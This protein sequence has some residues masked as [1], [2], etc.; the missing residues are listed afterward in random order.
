MIFFISYT[1]F[2]ALGAFFDILV[3]VYVKDLD[4]YDE[5]KNVKNR[6]ENERANKK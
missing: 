3:W 5:D 2:T 4:L 1:A 6:L